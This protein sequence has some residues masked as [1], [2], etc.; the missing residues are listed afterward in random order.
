[1]D[2]EHR[3]LHDDNPAPKH[4]VMFVRIS[5][6]CQRRA[7]AARAGGSPR[8]RPAGVCVTSARFG[9]V[10]KGLALGR[11]GYGVRPLAPAWC[12]GN[13]RERPAAPVRSRPCRWARRLPRRD[14]YGRLGTT[15]GDAG[16]NSRRSGLRR[17]AK[18]ARPGD[19]C[20]RL[21]DAPRRLHDQGRPCRTS[22]SPPRPSWG[23][24]V[25]KGR[26]S[27]VM[28]QNSTG[29]IVDLP[30]PWRRTLSLQRNRHTFS[31]GWRQPGLSKAFHPNK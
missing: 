26:G 13:G 11:K 14:G 5:R 15:L 28:V 21:C 4:S 17:A 31:P 10:A 2:G 25:G 16:V 9:G 19:A 6:T 3:R 27:L 8:S 12:M 7:V 23:R 18:P 29:G 30:A 22:V 24:G 20:I 1:M